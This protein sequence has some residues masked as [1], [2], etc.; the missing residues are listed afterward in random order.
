MIEKWW[1]ILLVLFGG[2]ICGISWGTK[3]HTDEALIDKCQET[4]GKYDFCQEVKQW[5][6]K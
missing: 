5:R 4:N 1:F 3:I 2:F 6:I